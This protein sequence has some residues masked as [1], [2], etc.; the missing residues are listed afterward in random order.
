[1]S[2]SA[3]AVAKALVVVVPLALGASVASFGGGCSN[4][5]SAAG[6]DGGGIAIVPE[7][8]SPLGVGDAP[9]ITLGDSEFDATGVDVFDAGICVAENAV[10][11]AP[12]DLQCTGLYSNIATKTL[13]AGVV[14]YDPGLHMWA[15]G[16]TVSRYVLLPSGQTIDTSDMNEWT[17]PVG[18]KAWQ[19]FQI[20]G[21]RVETR[22]FWKRGATDWVRG[23][24]VWAVDGQSAT[25]NTQGV[26][27]VGGSSYS[28][29]PVAECDTCHAGRADRLL[30]LEA[31]SLA[32]PSAKGVTIATL[33]ASGTLTHPPP[34][35][36][37]V[38]PDDGTGLAAPALAWL[39]ANCGTSCHNGS[40]SANAV[41]G[42]LYLRLDVNDAD[43]GASLGDVYHANAYVTAVG[44]AAQLAPFNGE[45]WKRITPNDPFDG[46]VGTS[47]VPFAAA[48][49]G[50]AG[51]QMPPLATGT[52]DTVDV[53]ALRAWIQHGSFPAGTF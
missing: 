11:G 22:W 35:G 41:V 49:R 42:G 51:V 1:M 44:V 6:A 4:L 27:N 9:V 37:L 25:Y 34:S 30:G 46:G 2:R 13:A 32:Q 10:L 19:E 33:T 21:S 5:V 8:G 15:D 39:H 29:P 38:I 40:P 53:N 24:Y 47:L 45:G 28:V 31:V 3:S 12:T 20:A 50:V 23:S 18:T 36:S 43:G 7:D 17:F 52:P 48:S 14:A 16:A 26:A